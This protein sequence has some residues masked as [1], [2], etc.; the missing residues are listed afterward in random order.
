MSNGTNIIER[1]RELAPDP[2]IM[3]A[4]ID[5]FRDV[6]TSPES[7]PTAEITRFVATLSG[8]SVPDGAEAAEGRQDG[9]Q[10]LLEEGI[11]APDDLLSPLTAQAGQI[12][13]LLAEGVLRQLTETLGPLGGIVSD[14]P[15]DPADLLLTVREPLV[16]VLDVLSKDT[17]LLGLQRY[18]QQIQQAS[19]LIGGD[20]QQ[21]ANFLQ[22]QIQQTT[23][24][25]T[26]PVSRATEGTTTALDGIRSDFGAAAIS[27]DFQA[28]L[29][30]LIP[31]SGPTL[32]AQISALDVTDEAEITALISRLESARNLLTALGNR[33]AGDLALASARLTHVSAGR[34][35]ESLQTAYTATAA[36]DVE[37][38]ADLG[39]GLRTTLDSVRATLGS[40]DPDV[41]LRPLRDALE[42]LRSVLTDIGLPQVRDRMISTLGEAEELVEEFGRLQIQATAAFHGVI[43]EVNAGIDRLDLSGLVT[44][45]QNAID[46]VTP[47]LDELSTLFDDIDTALDNGLGAIS[48]ALDALTGTLLDEN[49]GVRKQLEDFLA[50]I[51][52][53]L[54]DLDLEAVLSGL[55]EALDKAIDRLGEVAFDPVVE[56]VIEELEDARTKLQEI[57]TSQLSP[58][59]RE[60][61]R[62]ALVVI[63]ELGDRYDDEIKAGILDR[64][65]ALVE[66]GVSAPFAFAREK[67]EE[68]VGEVEVLN[69]GFLIREA[70]LVS[71][72]EI[73]QTEI[74]GFRPSQVLGELDELYT[75]FRGELDRFSPEQYL[76]GITD[77]FGQL[78]DKVAT[79]SPSELIDQLES[80]LDGIKDEAREIDLGAFAEALVSSIEALTSVVERISL[81][82]LGAALNAVHQPVVSALE[83]LDP[84]PLLRPVVDFKQQIIG[85]IDQADLSAL[86]PV[87][88]G[89]RTRRDQTK[90]ENVRTAL[91][92][93]LNQTLAHIETADPAEMIEQLRQHLLAVRAA[94]QGLPENP[95]FEPRK[96]EMLGLA[97]ELDP[98]PALSLAVERFGSLVVALEALDRAVEGLSE[99]PAGLEAA[100][101]RAG[102]IIDELTPE[103]DPST[104]IKDTLTALIEAAFENF[105]LDAVQGVYDD[106]VGAV[107]RLSPENLFAGLQDLVSEL[108]ALVQQVGDPGEIVVALEDANRTL[109]E[110][111]DGVSLESFRL[112]L[113]SAFTTLSEKLGEL[114]P[115]PIVDAISERHD[116]LI[117]LANRVDPGEV[118][119]RLDRIYEDQ[120][121]EKLSGLHPREILIEPLEAAFEEVLELVEGLNVD[122]V[123]E[124]FL[125]RLQTLREE[126]DQGLTRVGQALLETL[127]AIPV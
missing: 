54:E 56:A 62:V 86:G 106:L 1:V 79:L 58:L 48:E 19:T 99:P 110:A 83:A 91:A 67:F 94:V 66:D 89:A 36:L 50:G 64:Y 76:G 30:V 39:L 10:R 97:G 123:F 87:L 125:Q 113:E 38:L 59:L 12:R 95:A 121:A 7:L 41:V 108:A 14:M 13:Q 42:Q 28:L 119:E 68:L 103:V 15:R 109:M 23:T 72:Y 29:A 63:T 104:E 43:S 77:V 34:L 31:E 25:T 70:G 96:A 117:A 22:S 47:V 111:L 55:G 44:T 5:G 93:A 52:Q 24:V 75:G 16:S 88:Q 3:N 40:V 51:L 9:L 65:D 82:G 61:L 53:A 27:A 102:E 21:A 112:D 2:G 126:L 78:Q 71:L 49:T 35:I 85:A 37:D 98:F 17:G 18:S 46:S 116:E 26:G 114:D 33:V 122:A 107:E 45:S 100:A 81:D 69:P 60:A 32:A 20:P 73:L 6:P 115:A 80:V 105:P 57:D 74:D 124:P 101:Q 84:E 8:L 92:T 11:P 118:S 4:A 120:V 127:R 90:L